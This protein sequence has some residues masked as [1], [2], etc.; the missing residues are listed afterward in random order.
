PT[1]VVRAR[2]RLHQPSHPR[3]DGLDSFAGHSFHSAQWDHDYELRG[4]RVSV[5]GTGAGVVQFISEIVQQVAK[6]TVFPRTGTWYLTR[7]NRRYPATIRA[8]IRLIPGLQAF[9]PKFMF[10]Y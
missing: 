6:H 9:R 5:V 1:R 10:Q 8:A 3:V 2:A 4:K 7:K